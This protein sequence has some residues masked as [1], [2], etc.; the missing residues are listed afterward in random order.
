MSVTE[1]AGFGGG[2]PWNDSQAKKSLRQPASKSS[3]D[4]NEDEILLLEAFGYYGRRRANS[5]NDDSSGRI[6][7]RSVR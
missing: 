4:P 3:L 1:I 6:L 5:G 7:K 2:L